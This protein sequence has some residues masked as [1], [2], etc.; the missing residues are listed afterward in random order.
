[1]ASEIRKLKDAMIKF[2]LGFPGAYEDHPW[3]E[4]VVKVA[5]KVF[6]F[7]GTDHHDEGGFGLGVK[8][9]E[10]GSLA[11]SLP[12]TEPAGYGLGKSGWINAK[13]EKGN[14]PP[15]EMLEEWIEESYRAVAPKKMVAQI[16]APPPSAAKEAKPA[17]GATSRKAKAKVKPSRK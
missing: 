3:G 13:F 7:F 15:A 6:V 16:G 11:L 5:K 8:L 14:L 12:F 1:M 4:R 9:P 2:A 10:S 17:R